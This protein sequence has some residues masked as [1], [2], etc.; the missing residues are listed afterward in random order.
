MADLQIHA[1]L[2]IAAPAVLIPICTATVAL[3]VYARHLKKVGLGA[4]DYLIMGALVFVVGMGVAIIAGLLARR[5]PPNPAL[6]LVKLSLILFYRRVFT[7]NAAPRFNIVTWF[8]IF[9]I[10]I[11]TL[12]FFFSILFI[13]GGDFSAYWTSTIV[14]KAHCVD[15]DMLHNAFAISDVVTDFVIIS[16][17][18]PMIFGLHLTVARK[19]GILAIFSLGALTIAASIV[20][21]IVFIQATAVNYDPHA[22]FEFICTSGLYWSLI[23]SSLGVIAACLPAQY[24]LLNTPGVQS[25]VASVQSAISL[26]SMRSS[27]QH[28][29]QC[30]AHDSQRNLYGNMDTKMEPWTTAHGSETQNIIAH[31]EGPARYEREGELEE[32]GFKGKNGIVVTNSFESREGLA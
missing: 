31:A 16:L 3:R 28:P 17:P 32:G 18:V 4:D 2:A 6:G 24:G 9:I 13:C 22:D 12:S 8:M 25:L 15:T 21:M 5:A 11:W 29:S 30:D 10:I 20:R 14:E 27:S 7:R 1:N 23:E 26:R 19:I